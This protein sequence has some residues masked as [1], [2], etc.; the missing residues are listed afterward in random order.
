MGYRGVVFDLFHTL[1]DTEHARPEGFHHTAAT[2]ELLGLDHSAFR[3]WW[4]TTMYERETTPVDLVDVVE[5]YLPDRK[6]TDDERAT[7]D[8]YIGV[9]RDDVLRSPE[10]AMVDLVAAL[11]ERFRIGVLSN[12]YEREVRYWPESPFAPLVDAFVR[13]CDVGVMKPDALMYETVLTQLAVEARDAVYVANGASD[14]LVGA[15]EHGFGHVI[16][17]NVFDR[18]NGLVSADEQRRR[19]DQADVSVETIDGLAAALARVG[20]RRPIEKGP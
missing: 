12:C 14:E 16:H 10:P 7:I 6:L 19:A 2:A 9:A 3:A 8:G 15:T 17:V 18:S 13:S 1:V 20:V 4:D 5:R 11:S